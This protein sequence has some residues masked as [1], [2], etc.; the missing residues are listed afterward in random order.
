MSDIFISYAR[1]DR[2]RAE[3]LARHL[4]AQGWTVW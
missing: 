3:L 1:P 4:K 2:P